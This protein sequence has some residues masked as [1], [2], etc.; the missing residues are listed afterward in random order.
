MPRPPEPD[1]RRALARRAVEVLQ[2]EGLEIPMSKLARA[3]EIKRPTLLY[4]F[5]T[6]ADIA[7]TALEELLLEQRAYVRAQVAPYTHPIDRLYQ[8]V[9]AIHRFHAEHDGVAIFL[10]QVVAS[11][12]AQVATFARMADALFVAERMAEAARLRAG[13]EAG[14]VAPCD[15]DA[16]VNL[17]R[18]VIDG[19]MI[20]LVTERVDLGPT[21]QAL[22]EHVLLPL[23]LPPEN[24][25]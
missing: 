16:V 6:R 24:A 19:L 9:V 7:R 20:Q 22:W 11:S 13:I 4:H 1:K 17:V 3:L 8:R 5:P 12:G 10:T 21:H 18:A 25:S 15:P 23:K 14:T 2:R